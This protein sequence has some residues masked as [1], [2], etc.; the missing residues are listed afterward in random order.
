[1]WL[2]CFNSGKRLGMNIQ[3]MRHFAA[4]ARTGS[5][6]GAGKLLKVS[7]SGISQSIRALESEFGTPLVERK[8]RNLVLTEAGNA[9]LVAIRRAL[10]AIGEIQPAVA[11]YRAV[12]TLRIAVTNGMA[13]ILS[14]R[15][16]Q[17][18]RRQNNLRFQVMHAASSVALGDVLLEGRADL[19]FGDLSAVP[20]SFDRKRVGLTELVLVSPIG[21]DLP[22]TIPFS[23]LD[24]HPLIITLPSADR[25]KIF[26]TP[27]AQ[28][29]I[30]P[31]IVVE[32][33]DVFAMLPAVRSGIGSMLAWRP[34][35]EGLPDLEVRS[36]DP[37]RS[38][39][40][41]F[42][43]LPNPPPTVSQFISAEGHNAWL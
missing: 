2:I 35:V 16:G 40:V 26:D 32:I 43:Y 12:P 22:I 33:E 10:A 5:L 21:T 24:N 13:S 6:V 15:F 31:R 8:G 17:I 36:F 20:L 23:A 18:A 30:H 41:G 1:M 9:A 25:D 42:V 29:N 34:L 14:R 4:L 37:P 27:L 3:Q 28:A 11:A 39:M 38:C 7:Q 19:G